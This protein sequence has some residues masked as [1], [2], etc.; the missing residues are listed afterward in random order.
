MWSQGLDFQAAS[1]LP[2][3]EVLGSADGIERLD[4]PRTT[5]SGAAL[6]PAYA[7]GRG[8]IGQAGEYLAEPGQRGGDGWQRGGVG[9]GEGCLLLVGGVAVEQGG[10]QPEPQRAGGF[11]EGAAGQGRG[12]VAFQ[13]QPGQGGGGGD[14]VP[15][16]Q[17]VAPGLEVG[18]DVEAGLRG[19]NGKP[20]GGAH[21]RDGGR[22]LRVQGAA[23]RDALG[24]GRGFGEGQGGGVLDRRGGRG[25]D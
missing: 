3:D 11:A 25:P 14:L 24:D 1:P 23:G 19:R 2:A 17:V 8:W 16:P 20:G 12:A 15:G 10:G 22:D 21:G 18:V 13:E 6:T 9:G 4:A 5:R 7:D